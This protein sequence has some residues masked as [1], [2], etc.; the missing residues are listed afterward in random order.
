MSLVLLPRPRQIT[1][2]DGAHTLTPDQLIVIDSPKDLFTAQR[3]QAALAKV[4]FNWEII[5]NSEAFPAEM[6]GVALT[7]R[8][9]YFVDKH[10][11]SYTIDTRNDI[12]HVMS[13]T[14][15]GLWYGVQTLIQIIGQH[16]GGSIPHMRIEDFPD[17]QRRGVMLDISRDKVPTMETLYELVDRLAS[18]KIN[19]LQ[20][21]TEHTFA[22]RRHRKVWENASPMTGEQIMLLD[23]Y[24]KDRFIDLVPNQNSFGH[25][26]RWLM[27]DEYKHLAELPEGVNWDFMLN[28]PRPFSISPTVLESLELIGSLFEELLPHFT[29]EY[30]NVGCDETADLGRGRSKELVEAQGRGRVYLDFLNRIHGLVTANHRGMMFWGDIIMQHPELVPELPKDAIALE[31]G[32]DADHPFDEDAARFAAAGIQFYVCPGT[33]SWLSLLGRTPNAIANLR[34]AAENGLKHGAMG[35][36]NTDWGDY[37]HFQPLSVSYLGFAYGAA[38]S[39]AVDAN[40]DL[41]IPAVLDRYAFEDAAG[42]MGQL[43]YDLGSVYTLVDDVHHPNGAMMV[44]ALFYPLEKLHTSDWLSWYKERFNEDLKFTPAKLHAAIAR[45]DELAAKLQQVRPADPRIVPEY[46]VA[47]GLFKH[48]CKRLLLAYGDDS[49][50]LAEM[51]SELRMLMQSYRIQWTA[52]NRIGGLSDSL[53]RLERM[54]PDYKQ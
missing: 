31:W 7:R 25:M 23:R 46:E 3:L 12:L 49:V 51:D 20:L 45:M 1:M 52:R 36:L 29:S 5:A 27:H 16:S 32:Y 37:G 10:P 39:W 26:H 6:I 40:R 13:G 35:Y 14:Q 43:A 21:Y 53:V 17:F 38:L 24:C 42:M 11:Q 18:W 19:E 22:Y 54:L 48:G 30:F 50:S 44:R 28:T 33:S 47:I 4:G 34:S 8:N 9:S 2:Y 41:D 15:A